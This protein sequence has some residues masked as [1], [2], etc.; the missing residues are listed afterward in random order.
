M[1]H[2]IIEGGRRYIGVERVDTFEENGGLLARLL[3]GRHGN[4]RCAELNLEEDRCPKNGDLFSDQ[5]THFVT[6][7]CRC[8]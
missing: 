4:Q 7:R 3:G 5:D 1:P 8:R 2:T 6:E